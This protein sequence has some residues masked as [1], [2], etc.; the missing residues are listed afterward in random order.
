MRKQRTMLVGP[1]DWMDWVSM[2]A[3]LRDFG[4]CVL[5][6]FVLITHPAATVRAAWRAWKRCR[7]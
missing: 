6:L 5:T 2:R 3:K 4:F 1:C 7:R